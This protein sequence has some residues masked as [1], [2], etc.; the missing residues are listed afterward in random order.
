MRSAASETPA[1]GECRVNTLPAAAATGMPQACSSRSVLAGSWQRG[2]K[3][4]MVAA[5]RSADLQR[6]QDPPGASS[7]THPAAAAPCG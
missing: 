4:I 2:E 7:I 1:V 3:G 5:N 6:K